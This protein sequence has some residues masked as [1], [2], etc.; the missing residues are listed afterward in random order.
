MYNILNNSFFDFWIAIL[1]VVLLGVSFIIWVL[2]QSRQAVKE[3][4]DMI[5]TEHTV[6]KTDNPDNNTSHNLE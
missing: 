4:I 1:L 5:F 2:I 3:D 6:E